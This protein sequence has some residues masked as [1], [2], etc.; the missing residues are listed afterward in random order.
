MA[1]E[2]LRGLVLETNLAVH[3]V[4]ATVTR[5]APNDTPIETSVIWV[6]PG[7]TQ[8]RTEAVPF[9]LALQRRD[10]EWVMAL[11]I[12]EVGSVPIGTLIDAPEPGGTVARSWRVD[13]V[14]LADAEQRRVFVTPV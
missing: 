5:P 2:G 9:D 7:L 10:Q 3:G 1:I 11:S 12:A 6:T 8:P 4:P 13:S 14:D